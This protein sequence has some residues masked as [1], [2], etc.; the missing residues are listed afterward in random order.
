MQSRTTRDAPAGQGRGWPAFSP[1]PATFRG[2]GPDGPLSEEQRVQL[3]A[4]LLDHVASLILAHLASVL[5]GCIGVAR[6]E[7]A[8]PAWFLAGN[9][10]LILARLL[11]LRRLQRLRASPAGGRPRDML[12]A[13]RPYFAVGL[14][15]VGLN[16]LFGSLCLLGSEDEVMRLLAIAQAFGI[17]GG[18]ASRAAGTPRYA[19]L[20]IV[21]WLLPVVAGTAISGP[22]YW[23]ITLLAL[24]YAAVLD[25]IV[26]RHFRHMLALIAAERAKDALAG[27]LAVALGNMKQGLAL[28]DAA[29]RL[30]LVNR[31]FHEA[32]GLAP[33]DLVPGMTEA[34]VT[35]RCGVPGQDAPA[36]PGPG[37]GPGRPEGRL[38]THDG[39]VVALA[40]E[41]LEDGGWV[42]TCEDVTGRCRDEARIAHMARHDSLTGLPNR[43]LFAER[44][45]QAVARLGGGEPFVLLYLD[46]DGF[47][48]VNDTLGHATGDRLLCLVA[49]RISACLR[50]ADTVARLGGDEFAILMPG[51]KC[52]AATELIAH[53]LI[54]VI[55]LPC[56]ID[57]RQLVV[58]ASIGAAFAPAGAASPDSLMRQADMALYRAKESG[59]GCYRRFEPE[60]ER[61]LRVRQ[62]LEA[63][64]RGALGRGEFEL[65]Y[66]PI[67]SLTTPPEVCFEALLRWRR[68]GRDL[69]PP[70]SF[71]SVLEE[72]GLIAP[73][74]AWALRTACADAA[75]WPA[76]VRV[77]V[78]VSPAQFRS[79][80]LV[81]EVEAALAESR[82]PAA[83]LDL[84]ITE[85]AIL[86]DDAAILATLHRL[87]A[88]GIRVAL[89]DFG[90][91]YSSLSYLRHFPLDKLKID[92][93]FV[94]GLDSS[95]ASASIVR[96]I[97]T[98]A[99]SLGLVSIAEGV[100]TPEQL[101]HLRRLGCDEIQ[102]HLFAAPRPN[103]EVPAMLRR[104]H[105]YT[106]LET[107][108]HLSRPYGRAQE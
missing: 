98:L 85:A 44:M 17:A 103:E 33:D 61:R 55:G 89:D 37:S 39:R 88:S 81:A 18:T 12:A 52:P 29:G 4:P 38:A 83:R 27:R 104:I 76:S 6:I 34:E 71:I 20:Q 40:C 30:Q 96:A 78:N 86:T 100:E 22:D 74:G 35:A 10:I 7:A 2:T 105:E 41:A 43:A 48:A 54:R 60:M 108:I 14:V 77:A 51:V 102:G 46:L 47:K 101:H 66:Q 99:R 36:A 58:G 82:L 107:W 32:F 64:L 59:R 8:W 5:L 67:V 56:G 57:G 94:V 63:D 90:T 91:G 1:F 21:G 95:H 92:R 93:S 84:E 69:V 62:S 13:S 72:T 49:G 31:R 73:V 79:G 24:L 70:G 75:G 19:L 25:L 11:T 3:L 65:H 26:R 23:G 87:R 15:W 42:V 16:G 53:L 106:L 9:L 68:P 50:E 80:T 97:V 28:Y 45:E